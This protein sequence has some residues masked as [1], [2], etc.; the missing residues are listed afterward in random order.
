MS[1]N[2]V[3]PVVIDVR[4]FDNIED[5][6]RQST[7]MWKHTSNSLFKLSE[8][9]SEIVDPLIC[10]LERLMK[11]F[12]RIVEAISDSL[13]CYNHSIG[14]L[15]ERLENIIQIRDPQNLCYNVPTCNT[16]STRG[17]PVEKIE[18]RGLKS[19]SPIDGSN[20]KIS[21]LLFV[22]L[23]ISMIENSDLCKVILLGVLLVYMLMSNT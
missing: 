22:E 11:N 12:K 17:K 6:I 23:I 16:C 14:L 9:I 2:I 20:D 13:E 7:E 8:N 15:N 18:H 4:F 3:P 19:G 1:W 10:A 5:G 21:R